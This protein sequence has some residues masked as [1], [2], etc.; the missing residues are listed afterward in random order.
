MGDEDYPVTLVSGK[1][2]FMWIFAGVPWTQGIK[3]QWG[4]RKCRFQGFWTLCLR[5]LRKWSQHYYIVLF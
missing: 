2:R 4:N 5:H 3:R 1:I